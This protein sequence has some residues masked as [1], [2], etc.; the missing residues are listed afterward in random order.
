MELAVGPLDVWSLVALVVTTFSRAGRATAPA[1]GG[2]WYQKGQTFP[3]WRSRQLQA[4]PDARNS[5][6]GC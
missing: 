2:E 5:F 6:S 1:Y 3:K 4:A